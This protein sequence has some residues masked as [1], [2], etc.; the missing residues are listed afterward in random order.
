M[1]FCVQEVQPEFY[2][3]KVL[4]GLRVNNPDQDSYAGIIVKGLEGMKRKSV[5]LLQ[6]LYSYRNEYT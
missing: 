1:L 3:G 4:Q 2:T 6:C 5:L